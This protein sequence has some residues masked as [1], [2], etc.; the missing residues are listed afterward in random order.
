MALEKWLYEQLDAEKSVDQFLNK[1][2][3]ES[4]SVAFAGLLIDVGKRNTELFS[5]C[6]RSLLSTSAFY[7][8]EPHILTERAATQVGLS[9]W[10][11][12]PGD[13]VELARKWH[14][15]PHRQ[16]ELRRIAVYF[17]LTS[18]EVETFLERCRE[19]WNSEL[20]SAQSPDHLRV[21][22]AML[23]RRNY[24]KKLLENEKV[25]WEFVLPA[26][27]AVKAQEDVKRAG[28]S[29]PSVGIPN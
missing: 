15:A 13:L 4:E 2:V 24:S 8:W 5:T 18:K 10:W 6:L 21:L 25:S 1:I 16:H 23:D 14:L 9:G 29:M 11:N 20:E 17:M 28:D 12:Q 22:I 19:R 3:A 26:D 7:L 27:L